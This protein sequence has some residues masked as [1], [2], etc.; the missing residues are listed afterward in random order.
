MIAFFPGKFQPPHL[1]HI[2]TIMSLYDKYDKIIVAITDE[3]DSIISQQE[4]KYIFQSVFKYL[5]KVEITLLPGILVEFENAN[6]LPVFDVCL[7][8]NDQV[9]EWM[10]NFDKKVIKTPRSQGFGYSGTEIRSILT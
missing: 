2:I 4:R 5:D 10:K 1:G 3:N 8:G 6:L 7:S 9:V